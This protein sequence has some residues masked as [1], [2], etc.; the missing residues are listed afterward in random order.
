MSDSP[1]GIIP[2]E[3]MYRNQRK[4]VIAW[5]ITQPFPGHIKRDLIFAWA[6]TVFVRMTANEV[7]RVVDSGVEQR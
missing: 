3:Y 2:E 5:L 6:R 1:T 4:N 7:Q